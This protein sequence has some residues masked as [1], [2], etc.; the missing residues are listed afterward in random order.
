MIM[1]LYI[2]QK[3]QIY[4]CALKDATKPKTK[5]FSNVTV[6]CFLRDLQKRRGINTSFEMKNF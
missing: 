6:F 2:C 4:T 3:N 1:N 5:T